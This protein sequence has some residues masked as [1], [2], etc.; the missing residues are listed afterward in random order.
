[1]LKFI[2]KAPVAHKLLMIS[3]TYSLPIAVMFYL[4]VI[5]INKDIH[6][7]QMEL[8]GNEYQRPLE[9]LLQAVPR[10]AQLVSAT[11]TGAADA[12]DAVAAQQHTIDKAIDALE[13]TDRKIGAALQ[14]T[15]EG[16]TKRNRGFARVS[17]LRAQWVSLKSQLPSLPPTAIDEQHRQIVSTIRAMITH[18]G[19]ISNLI[20]DPD[21]DSYYAM[22]ATL[23][24]LPQTQDRMAEMV[25]AGTELLQQK[26]AAAT[27][28]TQIAVQAALMKESDLER[29]VTSLQTA[30]NEDANFY[31]TS[32]GLQANLPG[33]LES[34]TAATKGFLALTNRI[35]NAD[36]TAVT[37]AEY[38][39]AGN[40]AIDESF[41]LWQ[42]AAGELDGLIKKR[43]VS[44][45]ESRTWALTLTGIALLIAA[46]FVVYL[47]RSINKPLN[48]VVEMLSGNAQQVAAASGQL[49]SSSQSLAQGAS[50]QAASLEETSASL[51]QMSAMTRKSADT[52]QQTRKLSAEA[53]SAATRGN[54]A[55]SR[56]SVAIN[57]IQKSASETGKII[58]V[59]DE[60]A[61]QTNLLALN[62]AVE[63][64]RAGEAGKGFAVVAEEVRNLAMRSADA[65]RNT[66]AMI[67]QSVQSAR[68]GMEIVGDVGKVL[69]EITASST[70]VNQLVTEIAAAGQ[71]QSQGIDQATSAV[72]QMDK[73]TQSN[74]ASAEET[75]AAGEELAS[76]AE[77][78]SGVVQEL[79]TL[80]GRAAK[81]AK[82]ETSPMRRQSVLTSGGPSLNAS[83]LIPL[84]ETEDLKHDRDFS[85]FNKA[86]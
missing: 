20:L 28:R 21:L 70:K 81:T 54:E 25:R 13:A 11:A 3:L 86:A 27:A 80:V 62:A 42:V 22:D 49:A 51:K 58:K 57:Q 15:E 36:A 4:I 39:A 47:M 69:E 67:E 48:A 50:E 2:K 10:H 55:M 77:Q 46:A 32:E 43:I 38:T 83:K 75:A 73:V 5:G 40:K 82:R 14:F 26:S 66:A 78:L 23:L 1:M 60:I 85:E 61:F 30:I 56:M 72:G 52:A 44:Y 24:A 35:A 65:A 19:D 59:I 74:A 79:I 34:Y 71:E 45:Q 12:K 33:A 16:L 76:Q 9:Q 29:I 17:N 68:G 37:P 63:A 7:A 6:F 64:A 8:S 18:S 84:D 41:R 53:Q 31:G